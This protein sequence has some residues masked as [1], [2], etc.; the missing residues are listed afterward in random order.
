MESSNR[1]QETATRDHHHLFSAIL[2]TA[3]LVYLYLPRTLISLLICPSFL[4]SLLFFFSLLQFVSSPSEPNPQ[5]DKNHSVAPHESTEE[6]DVKLKPAETCLNLISYHHSFDLARPLDIIYEE[7]EGKESESDYSMEEKN[8]EISDEEDE[9]EKLL[10]YAMWLSEGQDKKQVIEEDE[11]IEFSFGEEED[12]LIELDLS[13]YRLEDIK[14][15]KA[16]VY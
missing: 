15:E 16:V 1:N 11:L 7:Y 5:T 6:N 13:R 10:K 12:N 4:S 2:T 3:L 14:L 9:I 8:S